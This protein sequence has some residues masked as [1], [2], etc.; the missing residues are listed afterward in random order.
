M[1]VVQQMGYALHCDFPGCDTQT[2]DLGDYS[3]WGDLEAAREEWTDAEGVLTDDGG[4]YCYTHTVW[5]HDDD[6]DD[7]DDERVPMPYTVENLFRL[8]DRRIA[9]VIERATWQALMRQGDRERTLAAHQGRWERTTFEKWIRGG[10]IRA[11]MVAGV[12]GYE[13]TG[14]AYAAEDFAATLTGVDPRRTGRNRG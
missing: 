1:S 7:W 5:E 14:K 11:D 3:F 9:D 4:A 13:R 2:R 6:D 12:I 8:A 10:G